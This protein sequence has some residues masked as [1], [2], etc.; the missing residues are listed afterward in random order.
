[1][2][3]KRRSLLIRELLIRADAERILIVSPIALTEQSKDELLVK[4]Y[5]LFGLL[6]RE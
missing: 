5:F 3:V 4:F 2:L 6:R 1:V